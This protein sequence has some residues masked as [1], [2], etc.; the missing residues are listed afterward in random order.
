MTLVRYSQRVLPIS[1]MFLL[2]LLSTVSTLVAEEV[3]VA[4][5]SNFRNAALAIG[6]TFEASTGHH[7]VY[8]F[9]STG[10]LYTQITQHAPFDVFLAADQLRPKTAV[11]NGFAVPGSRFTYATGRIVL[12]SRDRN[13]VHGEMT[14][15]SGNFLKLA[16]ADPDTAPYGAAAV[17]IMQQLGVLEDL[18]RKIVQGTNV[19]QVYQ[20]VHTGNAELGFVAYSQVVSHQNGSRWVVP[21]HLHSPISQDAVLLKRGM[22]NSAARKFLVYITGSEAGMTLQRFGYGGNKSGA[23]ARVR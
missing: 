1:F 19:A 3:R 14:I 4:V 6:E 18:R 16:I 15:K 7:V 23:D 12:F 11:E 20:F 2:G 13:L 8:S 17:V 10:L 5:A 21:E 22:N 9:G